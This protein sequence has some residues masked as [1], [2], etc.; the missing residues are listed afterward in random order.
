MTGPHLVYV[1][2][3]MC[4][5]CWGFSPVIAGIR[6]RFGDALPIRLVMGGL[7][8]GTTRPLD[9]AGKATIRGHWEHV[10]AATGQPFDPAFFAREGFVYDT[11]PA[12][13]AVVAVR[14]QG[15]DLALDYLEAL[16]RAF[17]AENRDV[18]D[19]TAL[20]DLAEA[21]VIAR[22]GFLA[23]LGE[24]AL[25]EETW[26]DV[27]TAQGAGIRG[28]PTL[29]AGAGPGQ[30]YGIVTRG[31]QPPDRII[32]TLVTWLAQAAGGEA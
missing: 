20:A 30:P 9:E 26:S 11:E 28:F 5:W 18:T 19:P 2:D 8:P 12:A 15:M 3:P 29:L 24:E 25:R 6:A 22:G 23:A 21:A 14:R 1:A 16:H 27:A 17:Y 4:S 7:R 31:Y 10:R 32:T 13:M